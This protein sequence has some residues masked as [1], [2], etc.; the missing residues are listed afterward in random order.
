LPG[1]VNP[2]INGQAFKVYSFD[3]NGNPDQFKFDDTL[4]SQANKVTN[5]INDTVIVIENFTN[6]WGFE[7]GYELYNSAGAIIKQRVP[8][9]MAN[10][11]NYKDTVVVSPGCYTFKML[12]TGGD[13]LS[14]WANSAQGSG[15]MRFKRLTGLILKVFPVDF[16]SEFIFNFTTG[17]AYATDLS[18][19][20]S[21]ENDIMIYPNP[22]SDYFILDVYLGNSKE[23][24]SLDVLDALGKSVLKTTCENFEG[25]PVKVN[26]AGLQK[27]LYFVNVSGKDFVKIKKLVIQ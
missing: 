4:R 3:P 22:A 26:T 27:G 18:E 1:V 19:K 20:S 12:D 13:G 17:A 14:W 11:S 21:I 25:G 15:S 16:G 24:I 2:T 10:N 7:N 6:N 9:T 5:Y 23:S 8:G